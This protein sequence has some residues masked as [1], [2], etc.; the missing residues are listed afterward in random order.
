MIVRALDTDH[1]WTFGKGKQN[2][3]K[4]QDAIAQNINTRLLSFL[5]DCFFDMGAGIDWR[6]LLG[7]KNTESEII[8]SCRAIILNTE[9]VVKIN[10][11]SSTTGDRSISIDYNIDTIYSSQ[12]QQTLEI[13][14]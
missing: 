8:L 4:E 11:F 13:A 6:R 14:G 7:D 10:S 9:D 2:Y 5:N 12:F 3:L 1:D